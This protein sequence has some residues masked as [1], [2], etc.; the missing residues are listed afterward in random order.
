MLPPRAAAVLLAAAVP[1]LLRV[2]GIEPTRRWL[3]PRAVRPR[4][5]EEVL[6]AA[7]LLDRRPWRW[8][9]RPRCLSRS[10]VL[11]RLLAAAGHP[12]EVV[13]GFRPGPAA[14]PRMIGHAWVE[15][16]GRPLP[17]PENLSAYAAVARMRPD[18]FTPSASFTSAPAG[19]RIEP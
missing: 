10:L 12:A 5:L 18:G 1:V 15:I 13:L 3:R 16:D 19:R 2:A 7:R 14:G 9:L 4:P 6:A 8:P 11:W 17:D